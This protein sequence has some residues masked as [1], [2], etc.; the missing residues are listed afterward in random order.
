MGAIGFRGSLAL[1]HGTIHSG[2]TRGQ[3]CRPQEQWEGQGAWP[4]P[5]CRGSTGQHSGGPDTAVRLPAATAGARA[6]PV[7]SWKWV[8]LGP[9]QEDLEEARKGCG[10][11]ASERRRRQN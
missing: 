4:L 8:H 6:P 2:F 1:K 5:L 11:V 3:H 9:P 10:E 7:E